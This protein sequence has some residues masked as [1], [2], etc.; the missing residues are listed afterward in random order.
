MSR[1]HGFIGEGAGR[2]GRTR[3]SINDGSGEIGYGSGS[4]MVLEPPAGVSLHPVP[5][6]KR[7][8]AEPP[9]LT[10]SDL[11]PD[12][13][14]ILR[15][16]DEALERAA[17]TGQPFIR[18]FWGLLPEATPGGAS[19]VMPNGP[20]VGN[21]VGY[22]QGGILYALGAATAMAALP[23]SWMLT[24]MM[25][26]FISPGQGAS[27][28]AQA[29]VVHQGQRTS[30]IRTAIMRSDGRQVLDVMSTHILEP[31]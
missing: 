16:A 18:H 7:G 28:K 26:A 10:E 29:S 30:V 3:V 17:R 14:R 21:R 19:C 25:A 5:M 27:L 22:V 4:F 6:R 15:H 13:L 8:D 9:L 1:C 11:E 24:S 2:I 20:H 23:E 31:R 12:E